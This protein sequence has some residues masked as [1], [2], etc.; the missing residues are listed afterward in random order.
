VFALAFLLG[1]GP[2]GVWVGM[3]VGNVLGAVVGA[4]WFSRGTWTDAYIDESRVDGLDAGGGAGE[5]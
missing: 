1:W 5:G 3:A 2:T 4:A